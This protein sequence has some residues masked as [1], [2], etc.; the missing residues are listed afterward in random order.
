M[1]LD[2]RIGEQLLASPHR[3]DDAIELLQDC[4]QR[5]PLDHELAELL[6]REAPTLEQ[7]EQF[8]RAAQK[9][10][11]HERLG[12]AVEL[13]RLIDR[14]HEDPAEAQGLLNFLEQ[15]ANLDPRARADGLEAVAAIFE[16]RQRLAESMDLRVRALRIDLDKVRAST[17]ADAAR[18]TGLFAPALRA[19]REVHDRDIVAFSARRS[20]M[21]VW[22]KLSREWYQARGLGVVEKAVAL[23]EKGKLKQALQLLR[24][25][26][27]RLALPELRVTASIMAGKDQHDKHAGFRSLPDIADEFRFWSNYKLGRDNRHDCFEY[28]QFV[29]RTNYPYYIKK[30]KD[31]LIHVN[32]K[33]AA[34]LAVLAALHWRD[35]QKD[36]A[37]KQLKKAKSFLANG[38]HRATWFPVYA[39]GR[40]CYTVDQY[41]DALEERWR[42]ELVSLGGEEIEDENIF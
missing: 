37:M 18:R 24:T 12:P 19:L 41:I 11:G 33:N 7:R 26:A 2:R 8:R 42:K 23:K 31:E 32:P 27:K 36:E 3:R 28:C 39:E 16:S 29:A 14:L 6:A 35:G 10:A 20:F 22:V 9:L 4:L 38:R 34:R 15:H 40:I 30:Y 21:N 1:Q 25:E 5:N 13:K 17:L